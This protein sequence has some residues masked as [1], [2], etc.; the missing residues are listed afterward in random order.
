[1]DYENAKEEVEDLRGQLRKANN[2]KNAQVS[3]LI[4]YLN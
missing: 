3:H 2:D 1:M 4:L